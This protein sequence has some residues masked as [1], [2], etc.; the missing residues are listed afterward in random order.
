MNGNNT[1]MNGNDEIGTTLVEIN[2]HYGE[3]SPVDRVAE[4]VIERG[5]RRVDYIYDISYED[6]QPLL[7]VNARYYFHGEMVNQSNTTQTYDTDGVH[8]MHSG[9]EE[10]LMDFIEANAFADPEVTL[11]DEF[12]SMV[13]V[14]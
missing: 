14:N 2:D 6:E 7:C 11:T 5:D 3:N 13:D 10:E 4:A 12:E 8:V 9:I 1:T